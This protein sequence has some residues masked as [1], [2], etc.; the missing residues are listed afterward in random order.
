MRRA[1][2]AR[3]FRTALAPNLV[4]VG[5]ILGALVALEMIFGPQLGKAKDVHAVMDVGLLACLVV[6]GFISGERCFPTELKEFRMFFLGSLPISRSSAWLAIV[7]AR[8]L[9]ALVSLTLGF[10]LHQPLLILEESKNLLGL[11]IVLAAAMVLFAYVLFFT[12]GSLFAL[13]FR[14]TLFSYTAG[15]LFL[16]F[17]L[18]E[19]LFSSSYPTVL[20]QLAAL[21][22]VPKVV[23]DDSRLPLFL[24]AFLSFLLV[25]W[26][27]LSWRFFVWSEFSN[28][29]RQIRNQ[30]LFA[31]TTTT[32][33]G[34]VFW[35]AT[36]PRLAS[37]PASPRIRYRIERSEAE[38]Y[39]GYREL[40]PSGVSPDG[41]YLFV[42]ESWHSKPFMV[43]VSI[44]DTGSGRI[45]GRT[46]YGGAR[47][48]F[49][50]AQG[51]VLN[52]LVLKNSPL[53]RWGYLVTGSV[54]WIRLSP[55]AREISKQRLKGAEK[56]QTLEEGRALVALR[57][58]H[59]CRVLLLDGASG[60][61]SEKVRAPLDGEALIW[62][63]GPT[64]LVYFK[65]VLLPRR[66]WIIDSETREV[67]VPRSRL[68]PFDALFGEVFDSSSKEQTAL[69]YRF[70]QPTDE[71]GAPVPGRIII[72]P[73]HPKRAWIL[74]EHGVRGVYFLE[75]KASQFFL[76]ARSTTL[77]GRWAKLSSIDRFA[78]FIGEMDH[79]QGVSMGIKLSIDFTSGASAFL[80]AHSEPRRFVVYDP[81]LGARLEAEG[82]GPQASASLK[83]GRA[84]RSNSILIR[85]ACMEKKSPLRIT[86][87]FFEHPLGLREVRAI[88]TIPAQSFSA[89]LP[90][91][92]YSDEHKNVWMSGDGKFWRSSPGTK[93]LR[94]WP[95]S[96]S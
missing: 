81:L 93:D 78:W 65:N 50:S 3:E 75:E 64:L 21:A 47:W 59:Q 79:W 96:H 16:G 67:R 41:R 5:A 11:D 29:K 52:L 37:I 18:I 72:L 33:L 42:F 44:V 63:D 56:I 80:P 25:S 32:Y 27:I 58:D 89:P 94:L 53:D 23:V 35:V 7:S 15:F 20:L 90:S 45:I 83:V 68:E 9:A 66:A 51:D 30:I 4:T 46:V 36:M 39:Y 2:F 62:E 19:T 71:G 84:P 60:R 40:L 49:W 26:L 38:A 88:A 92:V 54:D 31:L 34:F 6:S 24:I 14:R 82:C 95:P 55:E 43:Q 12:A 8:L 74:T 28:P 69:L 48:G 13:L 85:L 70:G 77:E 10:L 87:H 22:M 61:S 17:L 73:L 1:L 86:V 76:W 91:V 57:E